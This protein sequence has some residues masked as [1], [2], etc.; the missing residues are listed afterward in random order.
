MNFI[1]EPELCTP[2]L[3]PSGDQWDGP[4]TIEETMRVQVCQNV[5]TVAPQDTANLVR[6]PILFGSIYSDIPL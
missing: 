4:S 3:R 2:Q 1:I 5:A 6:P